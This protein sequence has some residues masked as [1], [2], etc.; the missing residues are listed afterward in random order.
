MG[1]Y[2]HG[3]GIG[4]ET[5]CIGDGVATERREQLSITELR[6]KIVDVGE[7]DIDEVRDEILRWSEMVTQHGSQYLLNLLEEARKTLLVLLKVETMQTQM[8]RL[9]TLHT[10]SAS[11][12]QFCTR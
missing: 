7:L 1:V 6:M 2:L 8:G 9:S 10:T 4:N 11:Y 12:P 5:R 3:S